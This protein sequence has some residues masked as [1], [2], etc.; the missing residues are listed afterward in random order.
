MKK[1]YFGLLAGLLCVLP[2]LS[3]AQGIEKGDHIVSGFFG[4]A[5]SVEEASIDIPVSWGTAQEADWGNGALSY[6]VQY[7]YAVNP[8]LAFGAEFNANNFESETDRFWSDGYADSIKTEMDVYS[9]LAAGRLTLNP[10]SGFRVYV[11]F[12]LGVASAR[13]SISASVPDGS[14]SQSD[15]D[16]SFMYYF[17]FGLEGS[18]SEKA[19]VGLEMRYSRFSFDTGKYKADGGEENYSFLALMLKLSYKF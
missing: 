5:F 16:T 7:L 8:Y 15:K 14:A 13:S 1:I 11:P 2:A 18:V 12:G 3:Y 9:L 19:A 17:G 10:K 4:G 6:G